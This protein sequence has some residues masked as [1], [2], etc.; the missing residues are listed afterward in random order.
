M[1]LYGKSGA[2][3]PTERLEA[4]SGESRVMNSTTGRAS[5]SRHGVS[6]ESAKQLRSSKRY[7]EQSCDAPNV[8]LHNAIQAFSNEATNVIHGDSPN[9][10]QSH[11]KNEE[12]LQ[13]RECVKY[14]RLSKGNDCDL[15]EV[16]SLQADPDFGLTLAQKLKK[17][18]E[19]A[20]IRNDQSKELMTKPHSE[21]DATSQD[22]KLP[23]ISRSPFTHNGTRS[24]STTLPWEDP[25]MNDHITVTLVLEIKICQLSECSTL[26]SVS[27]YAKVL[28]EQFPSRN[29]E[30]L[31]HSGEQIAWNVRAAS[32]INS[33]PGA[34]I[35]NA[36]TG[37]EV[38]EVGKRY[39]EELEK[40][41]IDH[42]KAHLAGYQPVEGQTSR[43]IADK[44]NILLDKSPRLGK[45]VLLDPADMEEQLSW[46][47]KA[48]QWMRAHP[49]VYIQTTEENLSPHKTEMTRAKP[50]A[51]MSEVSGGL[52]SPKAP[53][54]SAATLEP[55]LQSGQSLGS[56]S[57]HS[58]R[59][60]S[61]NS[62]ESMQAT[63][64]SNAYIVPVP[65]G[66]DPFQT[67]LNAIEVIHKVQEFRMI[68]DLK[69]TI[70]AGHTT[71]QNEEAMMANEKGRAQNSKNDRAKT[72]VVSS[73]LHLG[74]EDNNEQGENLRQVAIKG[75]GKQLDDLPLKNNHD[76]LLAQPYVPPD[77]LNEK[78]TKA[79][80]TTQK[81]SESLSPNHSASY[82]KVIS[83][84]YPKDGIVEADG[85]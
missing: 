60:K 79:K 26:M 81:R 58:H 10:H 17:H 12:H 4:N 6:Y 40:L 25:D 83:R 54:S 32:W 70:I 49:H 52:R 66:S 29:D 44:T 82:H 23:T 77:D 34:L 78:Q 85:R 48:L 16:C 56:P 8:L 19:W 53:G 24:R 84:I 46:N 33:L 21:T 71:A 28:L 27:H 55:S 75:K 47:M 31:L 65:K 45:D 36:E 9:E 22:I 67:Q 39:E 68:N 20:A 72:S 63:K 61:K 42:L 57:V 64:H 35:F 1:E 14:G 73:S 3:V 43:E 11:L 38:V 51:R 50:Q 13:E 2:S 7:H 30:K 59:A 15:S 41:R 18:F 69:Q 80:M 62:F 76:L 74:P 37:K 5:D